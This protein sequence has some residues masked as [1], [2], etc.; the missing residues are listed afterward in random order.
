MIQR[1]YDD[2]AAIIKS[3]PSG[4]GDA[5]YSESVS[6][7]KNELNV[8]GSGLK[9]N[10]GHMNNRIRHYNKLKASLMKWVWTAE[11][12]EGGHLEKVINNINKVIWR[13]KMILIRSI[14]V[15]FRPYVHVVVV[16]KWKNELHNIS[17]LRKNSEK[18]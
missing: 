10:A 9:E 12:R 17:K 8:S 2:A 15:L 4:N 1:G 11:C 18:N 5:F 6:A 3:Y 16:E 13:K 7:L 14:L